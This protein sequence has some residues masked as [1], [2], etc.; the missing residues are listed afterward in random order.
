MRLIVGLGN[1]GRQFSW[2]RHNV[3]FKCV[4]HMAR[5]WGIKLSERR[6]KAVLGRGSVDGLVVVL[7]KPRTFMNLSGEGVAY[8][9]AR[10]DAEPSDVV[11]IY[12]DMDLPVGRIRIRPRGSAAGHN[13]IKSI[14]DKLSD[15]EFPRVR[16]GIGR[17]PEGLDGMDYVLGRFSSQEPLV[18]EKAV[19]T[20]E[21]AVRCILLEG[22][23]T[24]MNRF[25]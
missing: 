4:D 2:S 1:P 11:I 15:Q 12:D 19:E 8:L 13:G 16:V 17:P 14:I 6:R 7:A 23:Q 9:L 24:A 20:V 25:N 5:K 18:I 10:F 3:G 21:A 22:I